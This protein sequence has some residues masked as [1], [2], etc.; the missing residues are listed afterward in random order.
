MFMIG[1]D[2]HN[3][4][5]TAAAVGLSQEVIDTIRVEADRHQRARLLAWAERFSPRT[6]A[7]EGATGMGALLAQQLVAVGEHVVDVPPKLSSR[8]RLLERGRIDKT[9]PND[10]RSAAIVAWHNP[11][12][13]IVAGL[14]EHRVVLRLLADRDH[15]LTAQRTRTICR[16][17]ALLCLLIEGGTSKALTVAKAEELLVKVNIDC[18]V[19]L[20]RIATRPQ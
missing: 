17:H 18:P 2:P 19:A 6:W 10:A 9:D 7:I 14:D 16:L 20:E 11:S 1:I 15:Q 12:L 8:V 3:G 4:S 5:H 13:N